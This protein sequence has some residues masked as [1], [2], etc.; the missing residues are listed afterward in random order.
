[1][2]RYVLILLAAAPLPP[3]SASAAWEITHGLG[4]ETFFYVF[5]AL[6]AIVLVFGSG[7]FRQAT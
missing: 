2:M 6:A 5:L 1:M 7:M 3:S 4:G